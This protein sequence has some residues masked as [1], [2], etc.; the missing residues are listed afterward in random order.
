MRLSALL[1]SCP[2]ISSE[3]HNPVRG[4]RNKNFFTINLLEANRY[5][6]R[7]T[8]GAVEYYAV[9][10]GV[11]PRCARDMG[12]DPRFSDFP[13]RPPI[14]RSKPRSRVIDCA[15]DSWKSLPKQ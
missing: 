5:A 13:K 4:S 6:W 11:F 14:S 2:I 10:S 7:A 9:V 3:T 15:G 12:T 1:R 8:S